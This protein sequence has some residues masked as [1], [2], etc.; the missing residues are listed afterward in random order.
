MQDPIFTENR[1]DL[2]QMRAALVHAPSLVP[3]LMTLYRSYQGLN[4]QLLSLMESEAPKQ[5]TSPEAAVHDV[6]HRSRNHF[7][8]LEESADRFWRGARAP[9]ATRLISR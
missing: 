6:F 8:E 2:A 5:S 3:S 4:A 1:P 9:T 7:R